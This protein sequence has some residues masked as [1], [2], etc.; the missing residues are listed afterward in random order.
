ML[1]EFGILLAGPIKSLGDDWRIFAGLFYVDF[2]AFLKKQ[3]RMR[4]VARVIVR[5]PEAING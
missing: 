4:E 2:Q 1:A 5:G 3:K